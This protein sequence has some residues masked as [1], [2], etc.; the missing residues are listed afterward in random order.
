MSKILY[1]L[2]A[3]SSYI[4]EAIELAESCGYSR[5][6]CV[7]NLG[8][9]VKQEIDGYPVMQFREV[10]EKN[11]EGDFICC[12][13]TPSFR[14]GVVEL[15][16]GSSIIAKSLVYPGTVISKR[17]QVSSKGVIIG[18]GCVIGSHS[19]IFDHVVIN[20]GAMVGHNVSIDEYAT[21]ES[22]V[23]IGGFCQI[24]KRSYVGTG[25]VLL[26]KVKVGANCIIAAG[27]VV[28]ND[29]PDRTMVSGVP[30]KIKKNNIEGYVGGN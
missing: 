4:C 3:A 14:Q 9:L 29:V 8:Q 11:L 28:R 23:S 24:G 13:H 22:N 26:P 7:D 18:A 21:I 2:G 15:T 5:I 10:R 30:A 16:N 20:R 1:I 17:A 25:A 6:V 19:E 27:A 12:I